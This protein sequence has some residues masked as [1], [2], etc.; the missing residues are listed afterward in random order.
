MNFHVVLI[1]IICS[2]TASL[3][4]SEIRCKINLKIITDM[5]EETM[6]KVTE[7]VNGCFDLFFENKH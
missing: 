3:F 6:N 7:T 1:S 5:V 4:L 2:V